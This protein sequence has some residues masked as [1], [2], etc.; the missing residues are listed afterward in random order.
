MTKPTR[1][2]LSMRLFHWSMAA[3]MLA[4][5]TA[6]LLMVKS[7]DP[8]QL[9]VLSLHK[10]IGLLALVLVSLRLVNR[11][12]HQLPELP[13]N[14]P[15]IQKAIARASH[16]LLYGL[17]FAMPLSGY[18][19]QYFA[20]RPVEV[21]GWFRLP[22]ALEV[23]IGLYSLF[24]EMHGILALALVALIMLHI[25]GA[26]HHHVIRKDKVLKTML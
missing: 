14:L 21:F 13:D 16:Y 9:T 6:G 26:L 23:N 7:L 15:A 24:R 20:G 1:F 2:S 12:R 4:M 10:A 3:L 25:A 18:A 5:L 11:L 22:A 8:W 19:M 17:M